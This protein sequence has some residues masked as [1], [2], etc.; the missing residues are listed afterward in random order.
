MSTQKKISP[1]SSLFEMSTDGSCI[2]RLIPD[3][4]WHSSSQLILLIDANGYPLIMNQALAKVLKR[5]ID[6]NSDSLESIFHY[7]S[8]DAN[9]FLDLVKVDVKKKH[10][11]AISAGVNGSK[12]LTWTEWEFFNLGVEEA[13]FYVGFF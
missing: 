2:D 5:S 7:P 13:V 6:L 1:S 11:M 3:W 4:L 10:M 8:L 9:G 12:H